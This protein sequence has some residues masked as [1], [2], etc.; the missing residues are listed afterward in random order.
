MKFKNIAEAFNYWNGK[1]IAEIEKRAQ[2]VKGIIQTDPNC[3]IQSLNIELTGLAQ[4]K[5]NAQDKEAQAEPEARSFNPVTGAT[6]KDG[7]SAEAVKG[8]V[9]ASAEYRSAFYKFLTHE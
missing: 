9:Y 4:A 8:D 7:A 6:F 3:D 1:S 5:A 2:E